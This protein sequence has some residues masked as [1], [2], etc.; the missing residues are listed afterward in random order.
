MGVRG[1]LGSASLRSPLAR[2]ALVLV[3]V[4]ACVQL[5]FP[6]RSDWPAHLV[7]GGGAALVLAAFL[8]SRLGAWIAPLIY[9]AMAAIG[10][11]AEHVVFGPPE[12]VD[13]AFTLAGVVLV[14]DAA[15]GV[16]LG[17]RDGRRG[18]AALGVVAMAVSLAYRYGVTIGAP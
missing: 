10:W 18:A 1:R 13:V 3:A 5:A 8:P 12:P 6:Y 9:L 2:E 16:A 15:R 11:F 7:G 4:A 17:G 14:L